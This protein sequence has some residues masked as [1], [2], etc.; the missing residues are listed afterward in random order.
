MAIDFNPSFQSEG[1]YTP[2]DLIAGD[3]PL[4]SHGVT[5]ASGQVLTRGALLGK[6]TAT[7]EFVL[8]T[9]AATDG[10]QTPIA[11]LGEDVDATGGAQSSFAY[12]AGDF[13]ENAITFGAG[14]TAASVRDALAARSIYL[15]KAVPN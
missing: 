15:H 11:I 8:S 9:S 1:I 14:H 2:D 3:H 6:I 12:I 13:N 7:G 4:R 10:S 5:I